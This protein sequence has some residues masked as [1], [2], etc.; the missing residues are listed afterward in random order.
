MDYQCRIYR[1][2][3]RPKPRGV[4]VIVQK[5]DRTGWSTESH[6]DYYL[7]KEDGWQA[8]DFNGMQ[9]FLRQRGL[10]KPRI[11]KCHEVLVADEWV[12]VNE[13]GFHA[14]LD[15]IPIVEA[16]ETVSTKR[17][18]EIFQKALADADFGRKHGYLK[19]EVRP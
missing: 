17:F 14:W 4:Q 18:Q 13:P 5:N 1:D 15:T 12:E 6:G 9:R 7:L 10:L 19:G 16:G 2:E 8:A 3:T 11:G